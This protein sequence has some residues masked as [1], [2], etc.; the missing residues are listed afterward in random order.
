MNKLV[1]LCWLESIKTPYIFQE[2]GL[3]QLF[4]ASEYGNN[5][6]TDTSL[7]FSWDLHLS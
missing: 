2:N 3:D 7:K 5:K 4:I 6:K 1:A